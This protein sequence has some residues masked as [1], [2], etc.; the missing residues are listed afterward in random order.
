MCPA[1]FF[2]LFFSHSHS[3]LILTPFILSHSHSLLIPFSHS[4]FL[5][6]PLFFSYSLLNYNG[7]RRVFPLQGTS[8]LLPCCFFL[9][10]N[11][12]VFFHLYANPF[13]SLLTSS[14]SSSSSVLLFFPLELQW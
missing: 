13:L 11:L 2:H 9:L 5:L 6:L 14:S 8:F 12:Y 3:I 7:R 1:W 4:S 10:S